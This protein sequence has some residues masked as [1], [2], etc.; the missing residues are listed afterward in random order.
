[1]DATLG[2]D[3]ECIDSLLVEASLFLKFYLGKEVRSD[4][5]FKE[6]ILELPPFGHVD[7]V[8]KRSIFFRELEKLSIDKK[9]QIPGSKKAIFPSFLNYI[10]N[11]K[12]KI[13]FLDLFQQY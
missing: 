2:N 1:M 9:S 4:E 3:N 10:K 8:Q 11:I 5:L 12:K 7:F 6:L 13:I